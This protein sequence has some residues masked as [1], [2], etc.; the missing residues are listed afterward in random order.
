MSKWTHKVIKAYR[1]TQG[2]WC[3]HPAAATF[4]SFDAAVEYARRFAAEQKGVG[5]TKILVIARK[6]GATKTF[7][8]E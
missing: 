3:Y 8:V 1:G 4:P 7:D 2:Q 5:G 6:G